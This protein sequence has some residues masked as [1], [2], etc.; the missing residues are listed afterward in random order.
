M[1]N[2]LP[3]S[4]FLLRL[5]VSLWLVYGA[6]L[7]GQGSGK[8]VTW[9]DAQHQEADWYG[10]TE[11]RRVADNL[12]VYQHATGGWPKN[13]DMAAPLTEADIRTIEQGKADPK[14]EL[15]RPTIDNKAT[16]PQLRYLARV[17]AH[18][19]DDRY[20]SSFL[21]GVDYLLEAQYPNGGWPQF[22]PIRAGYYA[23]ITYNDG[24]MIGV[25]EF[26]REVTKGS[27]PFLDAARVTAAQEAIDKG[28]DVILKTQIEADG[29]LTA[30]CAQHDP[31]TLEPARARA[32]EL[33]SLSG[34]ESV[35]IVEFLMGIEEPDSAV[36]RSVRAAVDWFERV[37][38]PGLRLIRQPD[39]S[40][41]K[42]YDLI[43]GFDPEHGEPLWARFYEIGTNYPMFVGRDGVVRYALS[44]IEYERRVGYSWISDWARRLL[45]RDYPE[46]EERIGA[47]RG[48]H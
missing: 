36:I 7:P 10:S 41:P 39:D 12:L 22:Y 27:Y 33:V 9:R 24:A 17:Y 1:P 28:T 25:L 30:W 46:W 47:G 21:R 8:P 15:G 2:H 14:Q 16:Y 32:Y 35:G 11:A 18:T 40:L 3:I 4:A 37:Q 45:E 23:N 5:L 19:G 42:G 31:E 48:G 20:K 43:V 26:L 6:A 38:L 13:M 44:E 29:R 34:S